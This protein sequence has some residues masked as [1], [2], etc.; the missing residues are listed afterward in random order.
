MTYNLE[1]ALRFLDELRQNN[2][3]PWFDSH[4]ADYDT[5][6]SCFAQLV[7]DL[8]DEFRAS[9]HLQG[10]SAKSCIARIYRD[11]RF[12]KDKTPYKTNLGAMVAPGGWKTSAFGYYLSLEPQG[13]SMVAG[14]LYAPTPEQLLKFR[15]AIDEDAAAFKEITGA[16]DFVQAFGAIEGERL[17]TAPKGYDRSHPEID[18]LQLKQITAIRRFTDQQVLADDFAAQVAGSFRAMK[19]FLNYLTVIMQ[20]PAD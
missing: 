4:R 12:S 13:Q 3:K 15:R 2:N 1:P 16:P 10:L 14:G 19:P 20:S 17:K 11:I 18:L 7:D 6:R 8:I 9:D 5:A